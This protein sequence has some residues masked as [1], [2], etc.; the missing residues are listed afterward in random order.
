MAPETSEEA[1]MK[2]ADVMSPVV[3]AVRADSPLAQAVRLMIEN[4]VSGLPV[5]DEAGGPTG[6]LTEGDLLQRAETGTEGKPPGWFGML[7]TPGRLAGTYVQTHARRVADVMTPEVICVEEATQLE[8]VVELMRRNRI[9]RVPVTRNGAVVGIVSRADLL[10]ALARELDK[11]SATASDETIREAILAELARQPWAPRRSL[12][13]AVQDGVVDIDGVV[14]DVRE[15]DAL[16]VLAENVPG[17]KR[18]ENRLVCVEPDTGILMIGPE[19][20]A[21]RGP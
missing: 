7:F 5:L 16:R 18:V 1:P 14:F 9:R 20:D 12:T 19:E 8:D 3:I 11:P 4:R 6:I 21:A 15:R 10:R 2:A 13:I 17:V